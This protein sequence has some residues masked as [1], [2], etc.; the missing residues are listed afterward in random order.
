MNIR[1]AMPSISVDLAAKVFQRL[2][3]EDQDAVLAQAQRLVKLGMG[4]REALTVVAAVGIWMANN[5]YAG[6]P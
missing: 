6:R 4:E 3:E 5:N 2:S 1:D